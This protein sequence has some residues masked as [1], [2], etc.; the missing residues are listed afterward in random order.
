[1]REL[2]PS[3]ASSDR[4]AP[5]KRARPG[6]GTLRLIKPVAG[7]DEVVGGGK[8]VGG[9][10]NDRG[11]I[12]VPRPRFQRAHY[13]QLKTITAP[14]RQHSDP[15]EVSRV[16]PPRRRHHASEADRIGLVSAHTHM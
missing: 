3:A 13:P 14:F 5:I 1:M 11:P 9:I 7:P 16:D 2:R 12:I 6:P 15:A 8:I 10:R 4:L